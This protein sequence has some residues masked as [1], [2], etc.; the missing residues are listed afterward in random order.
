V[1]ILN[2]IECHVEEGLGDR[3]V[4]DHLTT[5]L[6]A[7]TDIVGLDRRARAA[8]TEQC[9]KLQRRLVSAPIRT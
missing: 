2:A 9:A 6:M 1:A 4:I 7:M 3:V 5:A 8:V